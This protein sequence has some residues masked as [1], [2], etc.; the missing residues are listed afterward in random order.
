MQW[1]PHRPS[2]EDHYTASAHP[3]LCCQDS[4]TRKS[5]HNTPVLRSL[6]WLPVTLRIDSKVLLLIYKS[7]N[8]LRPKYIADMLT[9][10]TV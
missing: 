2:Q 8:V 3:E 5:E 10:Y 9:E 1:S 7:L 6:H 4:K